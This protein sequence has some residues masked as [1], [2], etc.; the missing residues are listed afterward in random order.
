MQLQITGVGFKMDCRFQNGLVRLTQLLRERGSRK[1]CVV[2]EGINPS[3]KICVVYQGINPSRKI[4]ADT[5]TTL[6]ILANFAPSYL[7]TQ[8]LRR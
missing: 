4:C 1:V 8:E 3:R 5:V 7:Y 2:C 6:N